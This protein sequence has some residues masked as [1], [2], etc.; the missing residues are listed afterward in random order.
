MRVLA[1]CLLLAVPLHAQSG[2]GAAGA[3]SEKAPMP[4]LRSEAA[5]V[6]ANG[7]L[8]VM[9]GLARGLESHTLVT[10]WDPATNMWRERAPMPGPLSHPN[11]IAMN[12]KI[13]VIGGF[14]AQVHVGAQNA[15]FE[16]DPAAD[17]WRTLAPLKV[18]R[19]SIAVAA[20][21][22]KI[23]A[24]GG[25]TPDRVTSTVHEVYDPAT[26]TWSDAAPLP[27]ARDHLA[28]AAVNGRIHVIGGRTNT[29]AENV[30]RHDIY[31]PV[32]NAWT[33]G[34]PLPTTRS[35]GASVF[36]KGLI[37]VMGGECSS[38]GPYEENEGFDVKTGQWR[39]LAPMPVG[40]HGITATT[41]GTSVL[42]AGGNPECGMSF[43]N[44]LVAFTLP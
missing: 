16:Y 29:P 17:R 4:D 21:N 41:D 19:G 3:W 30:N 10:E 27:V 2:P 32:K 25:R 42:I 38:G 35:G 26:N 39:T 22:G 9:G 44:R 28:V 11:G 18:A 6:F 23:H 31:D 5:N 33:T 37:V 8:Y 15:A 36:Y 24:I 13:Y 12:G 7:K 34:P 1:V 14:L 20:L 43:S 40:K